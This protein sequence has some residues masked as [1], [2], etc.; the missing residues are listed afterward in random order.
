MIVPAEYQEDRL[1]QTA[2]PQLHV[3]RERRVYMAG[4]VTGKVNK[5]DLVETTIQIKKPVLSTLA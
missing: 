2:T 5:S 4:T 3:Q 1:L